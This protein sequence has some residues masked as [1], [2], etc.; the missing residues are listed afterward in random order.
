[1]F[2]IASFNGWYTAVGNTIG[3]GDWGDLKVGDGVAVSAGGNEISVFLLTLII[4]LYI[5]FTR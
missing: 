1:M 5:L 3:G 4:N 2:D